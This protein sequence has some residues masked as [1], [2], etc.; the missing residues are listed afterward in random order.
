MDY[1]SAKRA[2]RRW[3]TPCRAQTTSWPSGSATTP[4]SARSLRELLEKRRHAP[5]PRRDGGGQRLPPVLRF[6][7]APQPSPGAP[8]PRHQPREKR[9]NAQRDRPA[10]PGAGA[11]A[12]AARAVVK[13]GSA[14]MEFVKAAAEDAYDR[15]IYPRLARDAGGAD[16]KR[17]ARARSKC[18]PSTSSRF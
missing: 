7:A 9:E 14:A 4:L 16:G 11:A 8:D 13:P 2:W 12:A 10:G 18:L 1:L 5:L 15:L 17:P 3:R 6:R